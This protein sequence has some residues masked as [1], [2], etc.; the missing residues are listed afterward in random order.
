MSVGLAYRK[1]QMFTVPIREWFKGDSYGWLCDSLRRSSLVT[2]YFEP[3]VVDR[4]L[5][6]H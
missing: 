2:M 3:A 5:L 1:K 6:Q 4:M